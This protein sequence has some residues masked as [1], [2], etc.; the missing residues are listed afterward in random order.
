MGGPEFI[1]LDGCCLTCSHRDHCQEPCSPV[2]RYLEREEVKLYEKTMKTR[3]GEE[4]TIIW[5]HSSERNLTAMLGQY[6]DIEKPEQFLEARLEKAGSP[7]RHFEPRLK[8]TGIFI[9]VFFNGFSYEDVAV[10]YSLSRDMAC[11]LYN[12]AVRRVLTILEALDRRD[13]PSNK[14]YW[15]EVAKE[16][17]GSLSTGLRYW[18]LS[19]ALNFNSYEIAEMFGKSPGT[20]RGLIIRVA[21]Q[22]RAG[23]VRLFD[24]TQEETEEAKAR[25]E[26]DRAKNRARAA[27]RPK[28]RERDARKKAQE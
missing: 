4:V 22:V 21:D 16:K 28:R 6:N 26:E 14:D 20:V 17:S 25:L 3:S 10:K 23:E 5:G 24:F 18:L 12:Q 11:Q 1:E 7:F 27:K 15:Q 13:G 2:K 9:D 8:Q 19:K